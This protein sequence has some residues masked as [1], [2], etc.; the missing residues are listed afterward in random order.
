[1][2]CKNGSN[3]IFHLF[4]IFTAVN[5]AQHICHI[6][7]NVAISAVCPNNFFNPSYE[8]SNICVDGW[9]ACKSALLSEW[10]DANDD[11]HMNRTAKQYLQNNKSKALYIHLNMFL[12][13]LIGLY[14]FICDSFTQKL[15]LKRFSLVNQSINKS[16]IRTNILNIASEFRK[17][18]FLY[19]NLKWTTAIAAAG[20][21]VPP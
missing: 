6:C 21:A 19:T 16:Y 12:I 7:A 10:R 3:E 13:I 17:T 1:M 15:E 18:H 8:M 20:V 2:N 5:Q 9:Y 14:Q 4:S 11:I